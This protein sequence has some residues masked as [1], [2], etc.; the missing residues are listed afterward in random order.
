MLIKKPSDIPYSEITPKDRVYESPEISSRASRRPPARPRWLRARFRNGS[1]RGPCLPTAAKL[2]TLAKSP[3]STTETATPLR[4]VTHYNNYYEFG[5][6][7]DDPAKYAHEI[8][9]QSVDAS[10]WKAKSPSRRNSMLLR[11][12]KLAPL[13]ERIYRHRCVEGW[14]IVVPWIGYSLSVLINQRAADVQGEVR[15][16][17]HRSRSQADA[18]LR[19]GRAWTGRIAKGCAWTKPCIR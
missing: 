18:G 3:F 9:D 11:L 5:T 8:Q 12:M 7:K 4:D 15:A 19:D 13:E 17:H 16:V 10:A 2:G 6:D 14:S 1:S